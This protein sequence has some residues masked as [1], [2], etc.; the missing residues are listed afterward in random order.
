MWET[1]TWFGD[2][3]YKIIQFLDTP[4]FQYNSVDISLLDIY[5]VFLAL[6]LI[7]AIFWRGAKT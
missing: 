3:I 7:A 2:Q 1:L 4:I 6:G 5:I